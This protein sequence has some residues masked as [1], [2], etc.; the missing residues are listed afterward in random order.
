MEII[1][2]TLEGNIT[3]ISIGAEKNTST[4]VIGEIEL[5]IQ[6]QSKFVETIDLLFESGKINLLVDMSN[7]SYLDSSG[8][9]ALFEGH[10]KASQKKGKLILINPVKDVKRVLDITKMSTK[11]TIFNSDNDAIHY[12]SNQNH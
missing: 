7:I 10:K 1:I 5:D 3:K 9:W 2:E 12:L 4:T 8:L 6:N 11:I